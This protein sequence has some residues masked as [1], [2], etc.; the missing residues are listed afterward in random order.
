MNRTFKRSA[1]SLAVLLSIYVIVPPSISAAATKVDLSSASSF[2]VLGALGVTNAGPTVI[3]GTAGNLIGTTGAIIVTGFPPG[4]AGAIHNN[5][6]TTISAMMSANTAATAA[7]AQPSVAHTLVPSE[8]VGPGAYALG[9]L[10]VLTGTLTLNGGGDAN[11][12]FIFTTNGAFMTASSSAVN[13]INGAQ[14]GNVFWRVGGTVTLGANSKF[15]G[16]L[17][18]SSTVTALTGAAIVGSLI[19]QTDAISLNSNTIINDLA[20]PAVPP[21]VVPPVVVPPVVV[22]PVVVPPVVEENSNLPGTKGTINVITIVNNTYGGTATPADFTLALRHHAVDVLG[23]PA[24]GMA[25]PGRSYLVNPGTYVLTQAVN[26]MFPNYIQSFDIVGKSTQTIVLAP[27]Q[28]ITITETNNQLP[29]L[30]A[31][32]TEPTPPPLPPTETGGTLPKTGSPWYNFLLLGVVGM[33]LSGVVLGFRKSS[34]I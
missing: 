33:A 4:T 7:L 2:G 23:S 14:A 5:D 10:P 9:T 29:P 3:T 32:G 34:K 21:V 24:M 20:T 12:V 11:S 28:S 6:A 26:T 15:A 17:V 25:T 18:A 30:T 22:P 16:H 1:A 13:L 8:S 31:P 27:G 19:S